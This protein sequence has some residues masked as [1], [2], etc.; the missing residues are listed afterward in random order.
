[1]A[2]EVGWAEV[3]QFGATT[4]LFAG[5]ANNGFGMLRERL[6]RGFRRDER[7]AQEQ[8]EVK[9]RRIQA[10]YDARLEH[11]QK[12]R[13]VH[14]WLDW[15]SIALFPHDHDMHTTHK[16]TPEVQ[17]VADVLTD[18]EFIATAHPTKAVRERASRL[19]V[20]MDVEFNEAKPDPDYETPLSTYL[21]W[22]KR[23]DAIIDLLH[24]AEG[25]SS[26][27]YLV[28]VSFDASK[29]SVARDAVTSAERS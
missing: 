17:S 2:V 16:N 26:P 13:R 12:A 14:T 19:H 7:V 25:G 5:L 6:E 23:L 29:Q 15:Q 18:L 28:T 3:L 4:G 11:L 27:S 24:D 8:H 1:M 10:H 21:S 9:L 20:D 22:T